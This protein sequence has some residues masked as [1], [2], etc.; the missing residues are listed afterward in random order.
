MVIRH[1]RRK[2]QPEKVGIEQQKDRNNGRQSERMNVDRL[3]SVRN[4]NKFKYL[5][6]LKSNN[7]GT[8]VKSH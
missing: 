3:K 8:T 1:C 6:I 7:N 2:K 4:R 5:D